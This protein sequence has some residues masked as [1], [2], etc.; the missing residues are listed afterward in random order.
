LKTFILGVPLSFLFIIIMFLF[1]KFIYIN[2]TMNLMKESI[3]NK[4]E[5]NII[6]TNHFKEQYKKL[7]RF[8]FEE[9][10]ICFFFLL[11]ISLWI[12]RTPISTFY[13]GWQVIF[14]K[15]YIN[16]GY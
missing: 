15:G 10:V 3:I 8:S 5:E 2:R 1:V 11:I 7:G 16:D 12:L 9:F 14:K 13:P 6:D 4:D